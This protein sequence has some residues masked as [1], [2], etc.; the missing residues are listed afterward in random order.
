MTVVQIEGRGLA[1]TDDS[2]SPEL[3]G[4]GLV[5]A[6]VLGAMATVGGTIAD[7]RGAHANH[8]PSISRGY[9]SDRFSGCNFSGC[10]LNFCWLAD[11]PDSS[12]DAACKPW[13]GGFMPA[14][15]GRQQSRG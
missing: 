5:A 10:E 14:L 15:H 7:A 4:F 8:R 3:S 13:R 11:L 12:M 2:V 1:A 9:V 6:A